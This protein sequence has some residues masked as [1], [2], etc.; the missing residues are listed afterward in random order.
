MSNA[1]LG[2]E[3]VIADALDGRQFGVLG[4][5]SGENLRRFMTELNGGTAPQPNTVITCNRLRGVGKADLV[6]TFNGVSRNV[7][8][9]N[10]GGG[11]SVHQEKLEFFLEVMRAN[12][13]TA[14]QIQSLT[15]Y[16]QN[17]QDDDRT[18]FHN[19]P[20]M[21]QTIQRFLDANTN[22][23]LQRF[24][25]NGRTRRQ[26]PAEFMY[27]GDSGMGQCRSMNDIITEMHTTTSARQANTLYVGHLT[28]QAWNRKNVKKRDV[29][30][31]KF[32]SIRRFFPNVR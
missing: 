18:I 30:Q 8:V 7:S 1:G 31:A 9:K 13:A 20:R 29:I 5:A 3:S 28:F 19:N 2:N 12:N 23:L 26:V 24:L 16:I 4:Q 14:N 32:G 15:D 6:I 22:L 21:Q 17:Y 25:V 10:R 27:F 11:H